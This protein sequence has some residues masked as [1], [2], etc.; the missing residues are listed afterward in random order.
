MRLIK[1]T[2]A[3]VRLERDGSVLVID[4]GVFSEAEALAG[5]T[6]VLVTHEHP[7]HLDEASLRAACA[8]DPQLRV[9]T[10]AELAGKL[11]GLPVTAVGVGEEFTAAGFRVR[12]YGGQHAEVYAGLPGIANLGYLVEDAV[13]HPGD[14]V[15]PPDA[16]V[17]VLLVPVSGPFLKLSEAIDLVRTVKP[18][19]AVPIHDILLSDTGRSLVDGWIDNQGNADYRRLAPTESLEI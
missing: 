12:A 18:D 13:Y 2:H 15:S 14:S 9:F 10:N 17:R 11:E 4:P 1:Y 7:D 16:P 5:A 8:A 3:C 6:A 19:L